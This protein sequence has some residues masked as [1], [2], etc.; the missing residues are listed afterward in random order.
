ML[1]LSG[2]LR[3][4]GTAGVVAVGLVVA[5]GAAGPAAV[6][7]SSA[8]AQSTAFPAAAMA[9]RTTAV[10]GGTSQ[11]EAAPAG[12]HSTGRV[13]PLLRPGHLSSGAAAATTAAAPRVSSS[14]TATGSSGPA[15]SFEGLNALD[16]KAASGFD[17]EPPDE[18]LGAGNGYVVNFIN[19]AGGIYN[20]SGTRLVGPFYLNTFFG[21]PAAANTSDPRVFF[22]SS[23]NRWFA[24]MLEYAISPKGLFTESHVDIATSTTAD[25][26]DP[27]RIVQIPTT[28]LGHAG[29][30][31]L[32]DYPILGVDTHNIYVSTNEFNQT[33]TTFNG[34]QLYAVSKP[35]LVAGAKVVNVASYQDLSAGGTVGYHVQPANTYGDPGVEYLM[36]SLDPNSTFDNRLAVWALNDPASVTTGGLPALTV[37]VISSEAYS[38]PPNAQTPPGFCSGSLC[39]PHGL[40]T[41]GTVSTDFDAMQEV[42][43][44]NGVLVGAL[45]TGVTVPGDPA[46]R[47]GVA[48][49][50]VHPESSGGAVGAGTKVMRQGYIS[51][52][53]AYLL[54]PHLNM[55]PSGSM[56]VVFG[57]GGPSTYLS[58]GYAT[59]PVGGTFGQ[60]KVAGAGVAPDNGFTGTAPFGGSGRWGDYSNG[61]IIPGTNDVWLATQDIPNTG[62][63]NANW[64]N[65]IFRLDLP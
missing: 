46:E 11:F 12:S 3:R 6:A 28:N 52:N 22:D 8:V 43:Y 51:Q 7:N 57:I 47:S 56:A 35:Q 36:S 62:D 20:S 16:N 32:A 54:Y 29:C 25:P 40:A 38:F 48:W 9:T 21:E 27:W 55:T 10:A 63:G 4:T 26:R 53:G 31:C 34:A 5:A 23:S 50:V 60:I 45:N 1:T 14:G 49:F 61:Q 64:G 33:G 19:V 41:T 13:L 44:I 18:G 59:A 37:K 17:L 15:R 24:T 58:A 30:P 2:R 39:A 65:R 42:Q